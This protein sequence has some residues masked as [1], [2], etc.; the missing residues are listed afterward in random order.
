MKT[1]LTASGILAEGG[2]SGWNLIA[3]VPTTIAA[4]VAFL[5]WNQSRKRDSAQQ[6]QASRDS[7]LSEVRAAF[8]MQKSLAEQAS[9]RAD[10]AEKRAD[11]LQQQIAELNDKL[12]E[13]EAINKAY[14]AEFDSY[15]YEALV[16]QDEM[17]KQLEHALETIEML[18][19]QMASLQKSS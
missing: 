11:G 6:G 16:R 14:R 17:R 9:D 2:L 19:S 4:L 18:R 15:R 8:E 3:I 10:R 12:S 1:A 5:A 13:Q 7:E